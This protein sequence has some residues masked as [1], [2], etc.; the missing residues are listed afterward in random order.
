MDSFTGLKCRREMTRQQKEKKTTMEIYSFK[1]VFH[2]FLGTLSTGLN[3]VSS[4]PFP[5]N[6]LGI[7][8]D[9]VFCCYFARKGIF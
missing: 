4:R 2:E 1:P 8:E 3:D 9:Y 6:R 5:P 7:A